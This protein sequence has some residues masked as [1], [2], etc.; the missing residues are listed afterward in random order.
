MSESSTIRWDRDEDGIVVLTLDD[1]NQS[2]N[3]MNAAYKASMAATVDRLEAERDEIT[4]V[5]ITSAKND[6]LRRRR[7]ARA[8]AGD[9]GRCA[10]DRDRDARDKTSAAPP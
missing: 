6:L 1:P 8:Q 2:A 5:V 9:E 10:A 4:G 7:P 3:T